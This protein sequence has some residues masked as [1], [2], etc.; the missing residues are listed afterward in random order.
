MFKLM[1]LT[2]Q[3]DLSH[4]CWLSPMRPEKGERKVNGARKSLLEWLCVKWLQTRGC[5]PECGQKGDIDKDVRTLTWN[6]K[7]KE[8]RKLTS[9]RI[10]RRGAASNDSPNRALLRAALDPRASGGSYMEK[11]TP[12]YCTNWVL[13]GNACGNGTTAGGR[14]QGVPALLTIYRL[15]SKNFHGWRKTHG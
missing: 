7:S 2:C 5:V 8:L 10:R 12:L 9:Q 3:F 6:Q 13:A 11:E 14:K 4:C 1:N 15:F